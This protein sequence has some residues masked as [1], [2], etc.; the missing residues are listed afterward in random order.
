MTSDQALIQP[1]SGL[2][3][4][5]GRAA[6]VIAPPYDV[7]DAEEARRR[8][9]GRPHSFLHISRAEVDLPAGTDPYDPQVYARARA[10]LDAMR[11]AGVLC[12]DPAP[13]YYAYRLD[14]GGRQ[15]TGLVAGASVA[16]YA[17]GRIKKH[18]LTRPAKE[19][20]RVRQ[21]DALDAQTGPVF[22]V[23]RATAA[24][25]D[26]LAQTCDAA[27][28]DVDVTAPDGVRHRLWVIAAPEAIAAL[29]EAGA[30]LPALYIADGHH[31]AAAAARVATERGTAG[32]GRFLAVLFAHDELDILPYHR[33]VQDLN[34]L[35]RDALLIRIGER[36]DVQPADAPVQPTA[37]TEFG[38]YCDGRWWRLRLRDAFL[39]TATDPVSR[40]AVSLVHE[41]LVAP[42]LGITDP[43]R[44]ARIDFVGGSRGLDGLM[45]PVDAGRMRL[46]LSLPPT[47][48][49]ELFAVADA[50]AIMPP[51]S[52]WFEPKLAD[53]LVSLLL[54]PLPE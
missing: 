24:M 5:P 27:A 47:G 50:G 1:F 3:P 41:H 52:T 36:F 29:T 15:Q 38:L 25:R 13:H 11:A 16:A 37:R 31:R 39:P 7:V 32:H 42:V 9:A 43:R 22:L 30:A 26:L 2:R 19:D 33:V 40:L 35:D 46:A 48:I 23:H 12:L 53:G 4:A 18:E 10:S 17:A 20:D 6:E 8:V 21:I 45:A 44:D 34:G 28:P 54:D 49:E 14:L 51:K